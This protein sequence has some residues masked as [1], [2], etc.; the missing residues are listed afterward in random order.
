LEELTPLA[1]KHFYVEKEKAANLAG[2]GDEDYV[3]EPT[4][5]YVSE[6]LRG[7]RLLYEC[8][9]LAGDV[10][11]CKESEGMKIIEA[12]KEKEDRHGN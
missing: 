6:L 9:D 5:K 7:A 3:P 1:Q 2:D 4:P 10:S 8:A 12:V 11:Y